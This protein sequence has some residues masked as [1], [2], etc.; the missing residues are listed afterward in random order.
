M[1][2]T[3]INLN[4]VR[5]ARA[6]VAAKKQADRNAVI[7]GLPKAERK[8]AKAEAERERVRLDA[9]RKDDTD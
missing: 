3:P 1:T 2:G 4:K 6:K 7:H 8:R 9:G 5:K